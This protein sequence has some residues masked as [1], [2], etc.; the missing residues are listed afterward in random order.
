MERST[1]SFSRIYTDLDCCKDPKE[2]WKGTC[3]ESRTERRR[4]AETQ[5][6]CSTYAGRL[7]LDRLANSSF[8][9]EFATFACVHVCVLCARPRRLLS[10]FPRRLAGSDVCLQTHRLEGDVTKTPRSLWALSRSLSSFSS[11]ALREVQSKQTAALHA[12]PRHPSPYFFDLWHFCA[13]FRKLSLNF[14]EGTAN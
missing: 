14:L 10:L 13:I 7:E 1:A 5:E 9:R 2:Q 6:R 4:F 12:Q 3:L 11:C 8:L